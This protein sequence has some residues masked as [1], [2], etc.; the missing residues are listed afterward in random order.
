MRF[1]HWLMKDLLPYA[2]WKRWLVWRTNH[3]AA[4]SDRPPRGRGVPDSWP[5]PP[6]PTHGRW[7][8]DPLLAELKANMREAVN[9]RASAS[10]V[11]PMVLQ[12]DYVV[13]NGCGDVVT[14]FSKPD[15]GR[16]SR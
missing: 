4:K 10:S 14:T 6:A 5:S 16:R 12:G 3:D 8:S 13:R 1:L 11:I 7:D 15:P 9:G 2:W